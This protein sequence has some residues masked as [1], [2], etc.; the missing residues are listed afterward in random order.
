M[1]KLV[2]IAFMATTALSML[3]GCKKQVPNDIVQKSMS[4]ALRHAPVTAS[5][6][7]G[8]NAKGIT[9]ATITVKSRGKDNTG[10]AHVKGSSLFAQQGGIKTC[11]GDVEFAYTYS[12]KTTGPSRNRRTTTTWFLEHMKIVA[13]QTPGVTLKAAGDESVDDDDDAQ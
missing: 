7:C 3:T 12:Q 2:V 5:A 11:E 4:N 9:G 10:V 13:V 6:M 1:K 8:V